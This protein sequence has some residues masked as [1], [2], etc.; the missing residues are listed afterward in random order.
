[1]KEGKILGHGTF[2]GLMGEKQGKETRKEVPP[3]RDKENQETGA[4]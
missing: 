4:S 1:M 3:V 2:R